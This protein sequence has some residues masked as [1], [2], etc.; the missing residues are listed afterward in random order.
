MGEIRV[1]GLVLHEMH[2]GDYD[3]RLILLTKEKG[4]ITV[5]AKGARKVKSKFLAGS[6]IFSY[7]DYILYQGKTSYN[8]LQVD[9]IE[10]FGAIRQDINRLAYCLYILEFAEYVT[11]E[12]YINNDLF[13]LILKTLQALTKN[14]IEMDIIIKIFELKALSYLGYTPEIA[15]C[16]KCNNTIEL[17]NFNTK[18][19]GTVC[20]KCSRLEK[21]SLKISKGTLFTMQFILSSKVNNLYS[22]NV[23]ETIK[24]ELNNVINNFLYYHLDKK[25]KSLD[26]L[27]ELQSYNM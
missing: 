27:L 23:N 21:G 19:G 25:F 8:I 24:K 12:N 5:F 11:E 13:R 14:A 3:K 26:F 16:I 7:G 20:D 10:T 6:Q 22:F 4:K 17:T 9:L 1:R 15:S 18:L 2:I